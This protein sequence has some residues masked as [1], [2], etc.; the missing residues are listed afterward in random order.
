VSTRV[1]F[2]LVIILGLCVA[3]AATNPTT[4]QYGAFL[5]ATLHEAL[6]HMDQTEPSRQRTVIRDML[7]S[8]GRKVIESLI[9][10]NTVRTNYGLFSLF[11]TRAFD[12]RVVVV[13]VGTVFITLDGHEEMAKK[14]GQLVL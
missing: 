4:P 9:W 13:G 3:L 7:A 10:T 8:Q 2:A 12:V 1:L 5:E 14:L 11:E 6:Q